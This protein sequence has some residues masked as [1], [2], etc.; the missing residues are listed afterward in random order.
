MVKF[1]NSSFSYDYSFPTV[2]LAYFLRYPNPYATH[3][4]STDVID[5]HVDP[6]TQRLHTL[7]VHLKR[8]KIPSAVY[9]LLPKSV[10]GSTSGDV[11]HSFVLE[12]SVID[13]KEGWMETETRNLDWTGV[14]SVKER[15]TYSRPAVAAAQ[16]SQDDSNPID[17][18]PCTDVKT[19]VTFHSR[20]GQG[21]RIGNRAQKADR[22]D[23]EE[24]S[25]SGGFFSTWSR[26]GIQRTIERVG[27]R[28]TKDHVANSTEGMNVVLERLRQGGLVGVLEGM[29]RD[30][31]ESHAHW[32]SV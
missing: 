5:R 8:S 21:K 23:Q 30:R 26:A 4:L 22:S 18:S 28:R 25:P 10:M 19:V 11:G 13:L 9:K 17:D 2:T 16:A 27:Q 32:K 7:R 29:R 1:Y 3:V 12:S 24:P 20:F 15:Q 31:L 6:L 14:L